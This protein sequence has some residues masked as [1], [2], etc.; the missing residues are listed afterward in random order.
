MLDDNAQ[1]GIARC[2]FEDQIKTS[3]IVFLKAWPTVEVP[4]FYNP[5]T[6]ALQPRERTWTGMRTFWELRRQHNIPIPVNKDSLYKVKK[7]Y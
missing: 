4:Q 6:T 3:D 1:E 5:L 7:V 2:T